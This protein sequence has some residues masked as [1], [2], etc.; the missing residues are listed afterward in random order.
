MKSFVRELWSGKNSKFTVLLVLGLFVFV[1][2]G[3]SGLGKILDSAKSDG[4]N[5]GGSNRSGDGEL[6]SNSEVEALV[7]KT[8][9]DFTNAVQQ[10]DFNAFHATT[11]KDF[12]A[13]YTST[14]LRS[15]FQS[16]I[17]KKNTAL[18][19]L[20]M[21]SQKTP[22]FSEGP[23]IR[24]EKGYKILVV[25]GSFPTRP[26]AVQFENQYELEQGSWKI[27]TVKVKM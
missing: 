8:M 13:S 16:F 25:S 26:Y 12:Q 4:G 7:K 21:V 11:S 9:A 10:G 3:C 20:N 19:S 27:L 18:P 14:Q 24:T 5:N 17:D 2:L 1:A 15:E 22:V 6:P 23:S